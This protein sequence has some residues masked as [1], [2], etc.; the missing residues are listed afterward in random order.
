MGL[1][2]SHAVS[3]LPR[4]QGFCGFG[5]LAAA[6]EDVAIS[7]GGFECTRSRVQG[8]LAS[9]YV[10]VPLHEY[11]GPNSKGGRR[12]RQHGD[13]RTDVRPF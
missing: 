1:L 7:G 12:A 2:S 10:P 8:T 9:T 11:Q 3:G 6:F 13:T 4:S 5:G